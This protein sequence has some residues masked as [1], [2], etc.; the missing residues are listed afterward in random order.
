[1]EKGKSSS[2]QERGGGTE[3]NGD[4]DEPKKRETPAS[5]P[6]GC[7]P[8]NVGELKSGKRRKKDWGLIKKKKKHGASWSERK[9]KVYYRENYET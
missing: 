6:E 8:R 3:K 1:V 7:P 9:G 5:L 2:R 4:D